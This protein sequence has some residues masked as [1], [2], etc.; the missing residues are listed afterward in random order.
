MSEIINAFI[1]TV[2]ESDPQE[3][4]T[5][6]HSEAVQ[7]VEAIEGLRKEIWSMTDFVFGIF[8]E[9]NTEGVEG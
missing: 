6:S 1:T 2:A 9:G 4:I 8:R 7:L 5:L 3:R